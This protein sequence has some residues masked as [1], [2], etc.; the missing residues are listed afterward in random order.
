MRNPLTPG[1]WIATISLLIVICMVALAVAITI[2]TTPVKP[3]H[4]WTSMGT[5]EHIWIARIL[6]YRLRRAILAAII[7]AGLATAGGSFQ[8]ILRNPLAEP[9]LLG[10]MG[11]GS[12][13]AVLALALITYVAEAGSALVGGSEGGGLAGTA[14]HVGHAAQDEAAWAPVHERRDVLEALIEHGDHDDGRRR[15][16]AEGAGAYAHLGPAIARMG[17]GEGPEGQ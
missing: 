9:Y 2:G 12:I 13:G 14:V 16:A 5:Q 10:V 11:G 7:G 6:D 4:F 3:W 15:V 17:A 1:R 8:A